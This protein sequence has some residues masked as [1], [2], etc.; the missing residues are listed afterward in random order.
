M[1]IPPMD[2]IMSEAGLSAPSTKS[3]ND[4]FLTDEKPLYIHQEIT[5]TTRRAG[6]KTSNIS[7]HLLKN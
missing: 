4:F 2:D 7:K 3:P 5:D 6:K 1:E